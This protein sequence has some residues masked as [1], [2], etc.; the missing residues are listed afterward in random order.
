MRFL[1]ILLAATSARSVAQQ[2]CGGGPTSSDDTNLGISTF[3]GENT[4]T[5]TPV[6]PGTIGVDNRTSEALIFRE[7]RNYTGSIINHTSCDFYYT[8]VASAWIDFNFNRNFEASERVFSSSIVPP[9]L[10][11]VSISVPRGMSGL[12]RMRVMLREGGAL[13]LNACSTFTWGAV[14]DFN[15]LIT[16]GFCTEGGPTSPD[17]AH[18]SSFSLVG[19]GSTLSYSR[20]CPGAIGVENR[21][22]L[23]TTLERGFGHRATLNVSTCSLQIASAVTVWIDYNQNELFDSDEVATEYRGMPAVTTV[24]IT[25]PQTAMLGGTRV[26]VMVKEGGS[27]PLN[28]CESFSWGSVVDFRATITDPTDAAPRLTDTDPNSDLGAF[29]DLVERLVEPELS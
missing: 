27:L 24:A 9:V 7:G 13:P 23:S 28:P 5:Y 22:D 1:G 29:A 12:T 11:P 20:A 8:S 21:T 3:V 26:R 14:A 6:C 16:P 2:Y 25:V 15:V 17:D 18:L 19:A 4:I 10:T